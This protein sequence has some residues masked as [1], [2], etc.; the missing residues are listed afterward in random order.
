M[1]A[2]ESFDGFGAIALEVCAD[3]AQGAVRGF[4][5]H[6]VIALQGESV[7]RFLSG[8]LTIYLAFY[9]ESTVHGLDAAIQLGAVI[10]QGVLGGSLDWNLI[11]LGAGSTV[12]GA[13]S[14][15]LT[16]RYGNEALRY[17]AMTT[18]LLYVLSALLMGLAALR[19]PRDIEKPTS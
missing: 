13:I 2:G 12:I 19:L 6:M 15:S 18:T 11:G 8:L 3:E 7:L 16:A 9:V 17:S 14:Q 10:A 1:L 4:V 5:D